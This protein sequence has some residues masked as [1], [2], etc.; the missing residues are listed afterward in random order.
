MEGQK[1][2]EDKYNAWQGN[3]KPY[4]GPLIPQAQTEAL[5][6]DGTVRAEMNRVDDR[7]SAASCVLDQLTELLGPLL[8]DARPKEAEGKFPPPNC[9]LAN[10]LRTQAERVNGLYLRVQDLIDRVML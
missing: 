3:Q 5:T 8:T 10:Q 4:G 9:G 1:M 2:T 6:R 7:I